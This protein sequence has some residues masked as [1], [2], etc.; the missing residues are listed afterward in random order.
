MVLHAAAQAGR[1]SA[2]EA[3]AF[4]A[5]RLPSLL[6]TPGLARNSPS[7]PCGPLSACG[8]QLCSV[9]RQGA[10]DA[11]PGATRNP[12]WLRGS[13][14]PM[15]PRTYRPGPLEARRGARGAH[16]QRCW[17][18]PGRVVAKALCAAE[19][20]S[21]LWPRAYSRASS[22]GLA[23]LSERNERSECSEFC[24][25]PQGASSTGEP[26]RR[27]GLRSRAVAATRPGLCW[28]GL[29]NLGRRIATASDPPPA[30]PPACGPVRSPPWRSSWTS[31]SASV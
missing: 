12:V 22:T 10:L 9:L 4:T 16:E 6:A 29:I 11:P 26:E 17:Q 14:P 19:Q 30:M 1:R 18:S 3:E 31:C 24:A 23:R 27:E 15:G 21:A 28:H 20:R 2:P 7:H 25:R 13:A 8:G 5:F